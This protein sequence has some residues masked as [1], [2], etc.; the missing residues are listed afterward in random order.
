MHGAAAARREADL[1][2]TGVGYGTHHAAALI[3][4]AL[5]ENLRH[6]FSSDSAAAV[7]RDAALTSVVAAAVDY[8]IT[9]HHF[10]PG[11]ELVLSKAVDGDGLRRDGG[12]VCC[13]RVYAVVA[14]ATTDRPV[15]V[16]IRHAG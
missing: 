14:R 4:A 9:P 12:G 5:F 11:W 3:W 8:T 16:V 13:R 15:M 10:T 2:H 7:V 1:L 6:R